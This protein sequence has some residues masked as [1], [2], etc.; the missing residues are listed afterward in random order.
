M[1]IL[2]L[3]QLWLYMGGWPVKLRGLDIVTSITNFKA[4]N[5]LFKMGGVPFFGAGFLVVR[6]CLADS[7]T[8]SEDWSIKE[9]VYLFP[10]SLFFNKFIILFEK[11]KKLRIKFTLLEFL[12]TYFYY[13]WTSLSISTLHRSI[14][15]YSFPSVCF[16][17]CF[18]G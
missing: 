11:I 10:L 6:S 13:K 4:P 15:N 12:K 9:S 17:V 8:F 14:Q 1:Q 2:T 7:V 18:F 16:I 3:K 5:S